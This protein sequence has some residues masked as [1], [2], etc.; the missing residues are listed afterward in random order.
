MTATH[1]WAGVVNEDDVIDCAGRCAIGKAV[2]HSKQAQRCVYILM[3]RRLEWRPMAVS[4]PSPNVEIL[5]RTNEYVIAAWRRI[6]MLIW[7]GEATAAGIEHSRK[8]FDDWVTAH[9]RGAAFLVVV[10]ARHA[11][12]PDEKTREA[13]R[14]TAECPSGRLKG[15]GTLIQAEGF[16]AA[17]IRSIIM[18]LNV[19]TGNGAPNVFETVNKAAEWAAKLLSD[20]EVSGERLANAVRVAQESRA[21]PSFPKIAQG[22]S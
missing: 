14:Q 13:M 6:L 15:M 4:F 9:P 18:R 2:C 22:S 8:V 10:P 12:P 3:A 5:A 7:N 16:V 17:S 1:V 19:L 20:P 11:G 21:A